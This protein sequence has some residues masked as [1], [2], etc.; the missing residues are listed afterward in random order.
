MSGIIQGLHNRVKDLQRE[1]NSLEYVISIT[2][3]ALSGDKLTVYEKGVGLA[4]KV[5][6]FRNEL[7]KPVRNFALLMEQKL[8]LN[9]DKGGWE[10]AKIEWLLCRL[11]EEIE[12]F[13]GAI[14][15]GADSEYIA[16]EAA[17]VANF[18]MMIADNKGSL[19]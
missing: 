15:E 4:A 14:E 18:A 3:K 19:E 8:K 12:E 7:R 9:D 1:I 11:E 6:D 16:L 17:D 5:S 13:R 10:D 2:R